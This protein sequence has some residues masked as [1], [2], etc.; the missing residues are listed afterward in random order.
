MAPLVTSLVFS[1]VSGCAAPKPEPLQG[2]ETFHW[3]AQP[4]EFSPPPARWYREG[5]NGGGMLGVRFVL[6]GGGGQCISV[7]AYHQLAEN[8]THSGETYNAAPSALPPTLTDLLPLIRLRPERMQEPS[9][10]IIAHERDTVLAG[11]PAF[12][13][14]DTLVTPERPLLYREIY[15]V[16][17]GCAFKAVYQG[18]DENLPVFARIVDSIR[19][20]EGSHASTH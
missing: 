14:F 11:H 13:S 16:V 19:F 3:V 10:W 2:A 12:V 15:W 1:F 17:G 7:L 20:P 5:D 4:I 8:G 6:T 9:R 18:T